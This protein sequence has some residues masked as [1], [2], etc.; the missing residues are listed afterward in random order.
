MNIELCPHNSHRVRAQALLDSGADICCIN[1]SVLSRHP[2]DK[3]IIKPNDTT[4][5]SAANGQVMTITGLVYIKGIFAGKSVLYKFHVVENLH[6]DYIIGIDFMT[7]YNVHADF[8]AQRVTLDP[9][10]KTKLV[11]TVNIPAMSEKIVVARIIGKGLPNGVCGITHDSVIDQRGLLS[12]NCMSCVN[13]R[14]VVHRIANFSRDDIVVRKGTCLGKFVCMSSFDKMQKLTESE[15]CAINHVGQGCEATNACMKPN[16]KVFSLSDT[17]KPLPSQRISIDHLQ[18]SQQ[19]Q[20]RQVCDKYSDA[21]VVNNKLGKCDLIPYEIRVPKDQKPIRMRP[22]RVSPKQ[23]EA[24][25][26]IIDEMIAQDIVEESVSPY[27]APCLLVEKKIW[28]LQNS[29]R[30]SAIESIDR[31]GCPPTTHNNRGHRKC[32]HVKASF[33][34]IVGFTKWV[35]SNS[36]PSKV[37]QIHCLW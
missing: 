9:R 37:A 2:L 25:D 3:V 24:M 10:R 19:N 8:G 29:R 32:W 22:Y 35:P 5:A 1:K 12:T 7:K 16:V 14:K 31:T 21:F 15:E 13:N 11:N 4:R 17:S 33:L 36:Y 34:H 20:L 30:L 18:P 23:K 27:S 26:N 28:R 6:T